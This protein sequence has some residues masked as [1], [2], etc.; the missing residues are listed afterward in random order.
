MSFGPRPWQQA[1]WDARAAGNFIGGGAGSGLLVFTVASGLPAPQRSW[2]LLVALALVGLGLLCVWLEIGRPWRA[3]NVFF[4]PKT[5]WMSREAAVAPLLFGCGGAAL[6]GID[7]ALP[8]LG[9]L[10]LVFLYC[11]ARILNAAKGIPA[12]RQALT[13]PLIVATGLTEGGGLFWLGT[14]W[15]APA[16]PPAGA[17]AWTALWWGFALLLLVRFALGLRWQQRLA[18]QVQARAR[19]AAADAAR[20]LSAGS[21]L[22]LALLLIGLLAPLTPSWSALL[23]A[24]AGAIAA[25][26]GV[27]YKFQLVTRAAFNQGFALPHLPVRGVR[28]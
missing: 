2:L 16:A 23:L 1:H 14:A 17:G 27:F 22:P 3:L 28:R 15:V 6:L 11:Q 13:V 4:N 18:A 10:A 5:S 9:A 24:L 21:L 25:A 12:W 20:G 26:G 19:A 8:L 7:A